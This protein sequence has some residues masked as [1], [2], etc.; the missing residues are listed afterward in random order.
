MALWSEHYAHTLS[1]G[2]LTNSID[3]TFTCEEEY[4][5]W[6]F[7]DGKRLLNFDSGVLAR[8][9]VED[10]VVNNVINR[11]VTWN[12]LQVMPVDACTYEREC[13]AIDYDVREGIN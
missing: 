8:V 6:K 11:K 7:I 3:Y 9:G 13:A 2:I 10:T 1:T 5:F 12:L 4:P